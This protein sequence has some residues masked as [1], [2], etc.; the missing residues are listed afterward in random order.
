MTFPAPVIEQAIE[1]K[2][3]A[4]QE[5]LSNAIQRLVEEDPTFRVHTDEETGQTIVAGM[6]ELHLDVF[7]DRMK[8]EFHV[9]ANIGKP[10][11]AYRETLRK[12]VEKYEYTHKK[13]TGGSGQ[14]AP[15]HHRDRA[16][17]AR[18]RL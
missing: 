10:Q 1:P 12:P 4:D 11:V 6:G 9:E 3:K 8:R 7:I 5:K 16:E 14:F 17:R 2:S 13:Q 18:V 15:R